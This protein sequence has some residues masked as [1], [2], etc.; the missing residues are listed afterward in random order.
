MEH[1]CLCSDIW[2]WFIAFVN[3]TKQLLLYQCLRCACAALQLFL[4]VTCCLLFYARA[5]AIERAPA[6]PLFSVC[7][8]L[9]RVRSTSSACQCVFSSTT[10][11]V[12]Q[13]TH[14][15]FVACRSQNSCLSCQSIKIHNFASI[16]KH[17]WVICAQ[18]IREMIVWSCIICYKV[19]GFCSCKI[20]VP[21]WNILWTEPGYFLSERD[22]L[23]TNIPLVFGT[24]KERSSMSKL[25]KLRRRIS[26]SFGRLCEWPFTPCLWPNSTFPV[27]FIVKG[28]GVWLIRSVRPPSFHSQLPADGECICG[29][30]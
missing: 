23:V 13:H 6:F 16:T 30:M 8:A 12:L 15:S 18:Q 24:G 22:I 26:A 3:N 28:K 17:N 20:T 9:S 19:T 1:V 29:V 2:W 4:P 7:L 27:T 5:P 10:V 11:T 21:H 14:R 25:K